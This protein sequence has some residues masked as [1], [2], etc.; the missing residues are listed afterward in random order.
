MRRQ[1]VDLRIPGE[2]ILMSIEVELSPCP[3]CGSKKLFAGWTSAQSLG[4]KCE[5]CG[6]ELDYYIPNRY[7]KGCKAIEDVYEYTFMKS[8]NAWNRRA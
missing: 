2:S 3:F 4:V 7:P 1:K 6:V 5:K 8:I